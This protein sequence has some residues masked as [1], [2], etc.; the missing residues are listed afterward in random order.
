KSTTSAA[1]GQAATVLNMELSEYTSNKSGVLDKHGGQFGDAGTTGEKRRAAICSWCGDQTDDPI[2]DESS[3][4]NY[5]T[6]ECRRE[7]ET[8]L[9]INRAEDR[10]RW[11]RDREGLD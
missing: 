10:S 8:D 7:G 11:L 6:D 5:C 3:G 9:A 4:E 1:A 2:T